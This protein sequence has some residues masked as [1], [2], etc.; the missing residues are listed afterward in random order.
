MTEDLIGQRFTRLVVVSM[1]GKNKN[2]S[3]V[4]LCE[5]DCGN[6]KNVVG[7]RLIGGNT[8]SCGCYNR[9]LTIERN[10]RGRKYPEGDAGSPL[11]SSWNKM[12]QRCY[13]KNT[14]DSK[15]YGDRGITVCDEWRD[16]FLAFKEWALN[17]GYEK[18][19]SIDRI[20]VNGNYEPSNC[21]WADDITQANNKRNNRRITIN[22]ITKT[23][24]EWSRISGLG[25]KTIRYRVENNW[26]DDKILGK[27]YSYL[28]LFDKE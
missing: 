23:L 16:N 20:D 25:H 18:D 15:D 1:S 28:P 27:R 4:W 7:N 17:N 19:L 12:I 2:G 8:K 5:C 11:Y 6:K 14:K 13:K 21:R 9:D 24:Q 3:T 10:K 26:P 22:G